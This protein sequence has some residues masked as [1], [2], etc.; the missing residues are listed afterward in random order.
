M[1]PRSW[2]S[3]A[4]SFCSYWRG[5]DKAQYFGNSQWLADLN[6][7]QRKNETVRANMISLNSYMATVALQDTIVQPSYSA[8]HTYWEWGD[9]KRE[10]ITPYNETEGYRTDA[11]GLQTLDKR[12]DLI[13]NK[14]DGAHVSYTMEWW[15]ANV[16]QM[17][18]NKLDA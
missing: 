9:E 3:Q 13:L 12:G 15:N 6:N 4:C 1:R 11:L 14:F 8:W 5:K 10:A 17:F 18:D 7:V 2:P 16:L